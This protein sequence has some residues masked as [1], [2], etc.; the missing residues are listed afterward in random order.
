MVLQW[1]PH[2]RDQ[3][4]L[5]SNDRLELYRA[6]EKDCV[7]EQAVRAHGRQVSDIHWSPR[8]PGVLASSALD[9][10]YVSALH[11]YCIDSTY[12]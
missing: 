4:A 8:Q 5:C 3:L 2:S 9:G 1:S 7:C 11:V 6:A 10:Q 12:I